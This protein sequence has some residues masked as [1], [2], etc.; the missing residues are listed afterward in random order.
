MILLLSKRLNLSHHLRIPGKPGSRKTDVTTQTPLKPK[1]FPRRRLT[2][3]QG[4]HR[5]HFPRDPGAMAGVGA[6]KEMTADG[7]SDSWENNKANQVRLGNAFLKHISIT[8]S[9]L[10]K[11]WGADWGTVPE[12]HAC[13]QEI[14]GHFATFLTQVYKKASDK[15]MEL[16]GVITAWGGVVYQA[17][18]RFKASTRPETKVGSPTCAPTTLPPAPAPCPLRCF[19]PTRCAPCCLC[20]CRSFSSACAVTTARRSIG[21]AASSRR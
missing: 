4:A 14:Y 20:V 12:E 17:S 2:P 16:G 9:A 5:P 18:Q 3:R 15:H 10:A 8:D 13:S 19:A 1:G 11:K 7:T 6:S 21:I